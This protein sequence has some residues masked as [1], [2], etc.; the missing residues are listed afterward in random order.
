MK[1]KV[2]ED[3]ILVGAGLTGLT[4]CNFLRETDI[5]IAIFDVNPEEFYNTF[6]D[7]RHIVLSNTSKIILS[8]MGIWGELELSL[9]HI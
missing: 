9:I 3:I 8:D 1:N 7:N 4:F 2:D 6:D 5:K